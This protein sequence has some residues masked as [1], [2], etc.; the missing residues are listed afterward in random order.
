[1][2]SK[3][4]KTKSKPKKLEIA[5]KLA[6][7]PKKSVNKKQSS[8]KTSSKAIGAR[9][10]RIP[11]RRAQQLESSSAREGAFSA[12]QSGD[13]EGLSR[14]ERADSESVG[15]LVEEGNSFEAGTVAGVEEAANYANLSLLKHFIC[16]KIAAASS[17]EVSTLRS[18]EMACWTDSS[19]LLMRGS[20]RQ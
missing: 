5:R 10:R 2:P 19:A 1:M 15:E 17:I 6:R 3:R 16:R 13:L 4:R 12:R 9:K 14:A 20:P 11:V 18:S 8:K 7:R